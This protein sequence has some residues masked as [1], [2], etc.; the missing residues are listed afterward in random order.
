M[1]KLREVLRLHHEMKLSGR[2]IGRSVKIAPGSVADYLRRA[3]GARP[4]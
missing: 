3:K 2:A 4:V 1:R